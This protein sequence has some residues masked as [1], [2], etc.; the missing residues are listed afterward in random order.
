MEGAARQ[1]SPCQKAVLGGIGMSARTVEFTRAVRPLGPALQPTARGG[2]KKKRVLEKCCKETWRDH[3]AEWVWNAPEPVFRLVLLLLRV[4]W[5]MRK[6]AR[7]F[8]V[9]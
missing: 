7:V 1:P 3:L 8:C 2:R 9:R 4:S 6:V 5:C